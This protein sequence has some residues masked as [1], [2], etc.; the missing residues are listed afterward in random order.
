M[1]S[2]SGVF[3]K[4]WNL[5]AKRRSFAKLN[6]L[7]AR[8]GRCAH[9]LPDETLTY[10]PKCGIPFSKVPP[11][12]SFHTL[13]DRTH[14]ILLKRYRWKLIGSTTL[15]FVSFWILLGS[16]VTLQNES[17]LSQLK[18]VRDLKIY[19][20][21]DPAYP[22]LP[23]STKLASFG[24]AVKSVQEH[25]GIQIQNISIFKNSSP[26]EVEDRLPHLWSHP[27]RSSLRFWES[28]VYPALR[29]S[30]QD[31][32]TKPLNVVFTNIPIINDLG[33]QSAMETSHLNSLGLVSG[34]GHPALTVISSYRLLHEEDLL[35]KASSDLERENQMAR[36]MGEYVFAHELGH[37][38]LALPDYVDLVPAP[39][40]I[41]LR[42]PASESTPNYS[43]CLMHTD[44][45]GGYAAWKAIQ[46]RQPGSLSPQTSCP[47]YASVLSAF[48]LRSQALAALRAGEREKAEALYTELLRVYA[49]QSKTWLRHQWEQE[50]HLFMSFIQR[51][52]QGLFVIESSL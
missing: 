14:E 33:K 35:I 16:I 47:E 51:W 46:N 25:F 30:W 43:H 26:P 12:H 50:S 15:V 32:A 3:R 22:A 17:L 8:C 11:T 40:H 5:W 13:A 52:W 19:I 48:K 6:E 41:A 28:E 37:A 4:F 20:H 39:T 21:E 18:P 49:P 7:S 31:T 36:F 29:I 2:F 23:Y 9:V 34:L 1:S 38:L 10:C 27:Q 24:I 42:G 44:R 45:G